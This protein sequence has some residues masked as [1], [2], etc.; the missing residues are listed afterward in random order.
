LKPSDTYTASQTTTTTTT[1]SYTDLAN[2]GWSTDAIKEM[3]EKGLMTGVSSTKFGYGETMTRAQFATIL[4]RYANTG[5]STLYTSEIQAATRNTTGLSDVESGAYYTAAANW[6]VS[7]GLMG[8]NTDSF[9]PYG[10]ITMEQMVTIVARYAVGDA[11]AKATDASLL[12][13]GTYTDGTTASNRWTANYIAW[14][15]NNKLFSGVDNGN[16][17]YTINGTENIKRER[18]AKIISNALAAGIL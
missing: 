4:W 1:V 9:D 11:T 6:A 15:I 12:T 14:G 3:A 5:V 10:T 7:E 16:G 8:V 2:D 13:N 18:A 17:T